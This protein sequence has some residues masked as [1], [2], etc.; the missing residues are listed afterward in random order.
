[1]K[2]NFSASLAHVLTIE[3]GFVNSPR[4]PGGATNH[5]VTQAIYDKWRRSHGLPSQDVRLITQVEIEAIYHSMFW[6]PVHGDDLPGGVDYA[7]FD[8][9]VNSGP[10][11]ADVCLQRAIEALQNA[12]G[13]TIDGVIGPKTLAAL[14]AADPRR[15]ITEVC[16]ERV[17]F[18]KAHCDWADF[19]KGWEKR[20]ASVEVTARGMA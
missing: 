16:A 18:M 11:E 14:H 10:Y 13:V 5:G 20:V 4:D 8:F 17:A 1:M 3:G 6:Q 7:T 2:D 15:I 12:A 19:G 9:A